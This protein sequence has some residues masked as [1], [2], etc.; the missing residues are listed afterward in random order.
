MFQKI[1]IP[2]DGSQC[3]DH[4]AK[5]GLEFAKRLGARVVLTNALIEY[6]SEK[7]ANRVT[8]PSRE[9]AEKLGVPFEVRLAEGRF[10]SIGDG[11]IEASQ[12]SN[13]ELIIMGTHGR[14][15]IP[16][17]LLGSV[18][19][20]VSRRA[21]VPVMLIRE[22]AHPTTQPTTE[23]PKLERILVAVDGSPQSNLALTTASDLACTL[24]INL[25]LIHVIPDIPAVYSYTAYEYAPMIDFEKYQHDLEAESQA[26]IAAALAL[27][28]AHTPKIAD[29]RTSR[30]PANGMR[31]GDAIINMAKERNSNLIVIGTH[32]RTG[33]DLLLLGSVAERVS[34]RSEVPVLM[35]RA[36]EVKVEANAK[37]SV[38]ANASVA[39]PKS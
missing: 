31:L 38:A 35:I 30:V 10:L 13:S 14:E 29:V 23:L 4:A 7:D 26:I 9:M 25:E 17:M 32:G 19:E 12:E 39:V 16:R 28:D 18:A 34:H 2:V 1:L 24:G 36:V 8:G 33:I 21:T 3:G 20:W 15:G 6:A 11:I 27:L 22:Q 5:F 37:P